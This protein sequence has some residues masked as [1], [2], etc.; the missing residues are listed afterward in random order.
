MQHADDMHADVVEVIDEYRRKHGEPPAAM[1]AMYDYLHDKEIEDALEG[2]V[3]PRL[4][5]RSGEQ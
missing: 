5:V 1:M 3:S 2:N 4:E